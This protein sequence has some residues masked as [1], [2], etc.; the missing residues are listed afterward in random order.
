VVG[1]GVAE[2]GRPRL[3]DE[4]DL[5]S[6]LGGDCGDLEHV[7]RL[8]AEDADQSDNVAADALRHGRAGRK[9]RPEHLE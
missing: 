3:T 4:P 6:A 5:A 2:R 9:D 8:V 7:P 1:V